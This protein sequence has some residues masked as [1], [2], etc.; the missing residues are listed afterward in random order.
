VQQELAH[1]GLHRV[2]KLPDL[3]IAAIAEL[4]QATV[5]HYDADYDHIADVTGQ[6]VEWI[7]ARGSIA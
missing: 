5:F 7:V 3:I 4:A 1:R 6:S 2:A